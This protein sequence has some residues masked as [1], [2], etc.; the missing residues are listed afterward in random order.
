MSS[1]SSSRQRVLIAAAGLACVAGGVAYAYMYHSKRQRKGQPGSGRCVEG[2]NGAACELRRLL[3]GS[4]S[5]P[6]A[7]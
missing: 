6:S 5:R 3:M 7:S 4:S 2:L 1:S